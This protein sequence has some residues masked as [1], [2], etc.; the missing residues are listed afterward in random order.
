MSLLF[1]I[2]AM[3]ACAH[4]N[5]VSVTQVPA[6]RSKEI[7]VN[8]SKWIFLGFSFDNLFVDQLAAELKGKCQGGKIQG[9]L[10]KDETFAYF[11][12]FKK[13]VTVTGFCVK[14]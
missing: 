9:I 13:E 10:T 11:I 5:S 7:R 12:L 2:Y 3:T 4:L 1:G 6:D 14:S 8:T